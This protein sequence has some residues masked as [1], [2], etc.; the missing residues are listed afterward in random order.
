MRHASRQRTSYLALAATVALAL[1]ACAST[2]SATKARPS[3]SSKAVGAG[4]TGS[5]ADALFQQLRKDG[6]AAKTVR[7]KGTIS[8]G[9]TSAS[10]AVKVQIDIAG[11]LGGKNSRALV[12]DG[13]GAMELLTVGG[14]TYIKADTAYWT[15]NGTAAI[16][17]VAA[18]KYIL[19]PAGSA[20]TTSD[21]TVGQLLGQIYTSAAGKLNTKVD[22]TQVNGVPAYVMT[23]KAK[24]TKLYVSA[25]GQARLLRV[26]GSKGGLSAMDFTEWNAVPP[27]SAPAASQ[28]TTIPGL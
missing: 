25:D 8:N 11:D 2:S 23:T 5:S 21:S 7:I 14:K 10:K 6:A 9:A 22:K 19:V 18:G 17:K 12:N 1:T 24:D 15:K 20:T 16:A 26:E 3:S 27:V 28:L 13:S 4:A